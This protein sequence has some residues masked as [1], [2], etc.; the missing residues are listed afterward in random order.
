MLLPLPVFLL[1]LFCFLFLILPLLLLLLLFL[2]R[3][4][5]LLSLFPLPLLLLLLLLLPL[6]LFPLSPVLFLFLPSL[7][8]P[9][10]PY[11]VSSSLP[12][13]SFPGSLSSTVPF[14]GYPFI[15]SS[16]SAL[17]SSLSSLYLSSLTPSSSS[18]SLATSRPPPPPGF[19]PLPLTSASS[20]LAF[21]S[22][23]SSF[24]SGFPLSTST[25][26]SSSSSPVAS[27][28]SSSHSDFLSRLAEFHVHT[29]DLSMEYV[30]L[31][32]W[33][34]SCDIGVSFLDFV[35][36]SFPHLVPDLARDFSSGSSHILAA[37][38][39]PSLS[40]SLPSHSPLRSVPPPSSSA[41][42]VP[43]FYARFPS[44][45][46]SAPPRFPTPHPSPFPN[47]SAPL[48]SLASSYLP[49]R[50]SAPLPHAHS[51]SSPSSL[52]LPSDLYPGGGSA[53]V[54]GAGLGVPASSSSSFGVPSFPSLVPPPASTYAGLP[55]TASAVPAPHA[56]VFD[57]HAPSSAPPFEDL[58]FDPDDR[59]F[60]D[61]THFADPSAPSISL[62]SS[63]SEYRRMVEYVLGLFPLASGVPPSAPLPR[64]LFESFFADSTPQSPNL[65]FNWFDR[66]RQ[67]LTDADSVMAAALSSG[68]SDRVFLPSRHLSYA[69]RGDHAG[70][71]AVPVN[72][73][74][75]AHFECPLR[76]NLLVGL[77]V[78]D[79][80][81]LES[82]FRGQSETLSYV[83]WVLSGLLGFVR[84]QGFSPSDPALFNQL[85][86]TLSKC[87]AHQASVTASQISYIC[88]K[89]R[90]FY[91]SH[92][93]AYFMDSTKRSLL[94]S[95]A[96]FADS[97]FAE[98]NISRLLDVT[99]S[100]SCLRSQQ[101]MVDVG[102]RGSSS[103]SRGR[104][105]SP[106]RSPGRSSP[107]RRRRRE[108]GSPARSQKR[109]RFDSPAPA[110]ALKSS[111]KPFWE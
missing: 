73:S 55:V 106:Q 53:F 40:V 58:V 57:P 8:P 42:S 34:V 56:P 94:E 30:D 60:D 33:F 4:L 46:L 103:S 69:L 78:R 90:E 7:L 10:T 38:R 13:L 47:S 76:L 43:P 39:T 11:S 14:P 65:H 63:R 70:F 101:A 102:S 15:P 54:Q 25:A 100:T 16:S 99:R 108:S 71:K 27:S 50:P 77:S 97:L 59:Q 12:P 48:T 72:E 67:S 86:T 1:L 3:P 91:L 84:L 23:S 68:R 105:S 92:L 79:T 35:S 82:S 22:S 52:P 24:T 96:V 104:R 36:S 17:A 80:M 93:P 28:S 31:A 32:K 89:R 21:A 66:V 64:A 110:S 26:A 20:S 37:L 61:E 83:L 74:L 44:S 9:S 6:L 18:P 98:H 81:A 88:A 49:P 45:S 109:V 19:P 2:L 62:D 107:S 111:R 5:L 85:V 29:L 95:L 51:S 75:L 41:P 87:L